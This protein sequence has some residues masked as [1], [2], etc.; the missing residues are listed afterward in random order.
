MKSEYRQAVE[1]VIAQ[2]KKL[3]EVEDMY[4]S[5]AAQERRLAEDLRLNRETL[6]QYERRVAEIES[7]ILGAGRA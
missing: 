3:A 6:S 5:A 4:A 7:Q 1:S 2:E